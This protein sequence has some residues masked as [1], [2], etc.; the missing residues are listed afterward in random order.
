[1]CDAGK[2]AQATLLA[3]HAYDDEETFR[4]NTGLKDARLVEYKPEDT[5]VYV[6]WLDVRSFPRNHTLIAARAIFAL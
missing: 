2:I 3:M 1:M 5:Q 4:K 6:A